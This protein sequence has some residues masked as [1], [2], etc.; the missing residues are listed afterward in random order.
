MNRNSLPTTYQELNAFLGLKDRKTLCNNTYAERLAT[1]SIAVVLHHTHVVT[2]TPRYIT[3]NTGGWH[4]V[5]TK[6]CLNR[7]LPAGWYVSQK[8]GEW[9]LELTV[10]TNGEGNVRVINE[11]FFDGIT[12]DL[13]VGARGA[14]LKD[15]VAL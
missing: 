1:G 4:T 11:P 12:I 15:E 14:L 5:T 10:C 7:F 8:K 2:L 6:D 3:L 9:F 13:S